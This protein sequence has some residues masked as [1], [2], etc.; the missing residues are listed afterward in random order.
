[1]CPGKIQIILLICTVWS[2]YPA[3]TFWIAQDAKFL[4]GDN[5]D[6]DLGL[7]VQS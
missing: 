3:G 5:Q 7:V 2:E 4:F 6:S 1:M